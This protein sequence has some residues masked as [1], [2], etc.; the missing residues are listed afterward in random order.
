MCRLLTS[1]FMLWCGLLVGFAYADGETDTFRSHK[2]MVFGDS[3]SAA[4]GIEQAEGWVALL[5]ERVSDLYKN[6]DVENASVS[7]ETTSGGLTRIDYEL[8]RIKPSIVVVELGGNDGLRGYPIESVEDNLRNIVRKC[9]LAGARVLLAGMR[10][11]PNYGNRY[12]DSFFDMY[13]DIAQDLQIAYI[14]FLLEN[15]GD[16]EEL[17]QNDGVHPKA[18]AQPIL[19]ENIWSE[20]D[21]LIK[22]PA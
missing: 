10:L 12:T 7:G 8:E 16:Q 19:L 1:L 21:R 17:M 4:Y 2:I 22:T 3:L 11:P 5:R 13:A 20:I 6:W 14:P 18:I 9:H 15:V